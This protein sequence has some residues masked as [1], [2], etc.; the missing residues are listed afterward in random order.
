MGSVPGVLWQPV[1]A[2]T[3]HPSHW[4]PWDG[5][6]KE[7]TSAAQELS[8]DYG[9]GRGSTNQQNLLSVCGLFDDLD[10]GL[11]VKH[12]WTYS[13]HM[14][15]L[16]SGDSFIGALYTKT[17]VNALQPSLHGADKQRYKRGVCNVQEYICSGRTNPCHGSRSSTASPKNIAILYHSYSRDL[18]T[19]RF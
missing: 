1:P 2:L 6:S 19:Q 13:L 5:F 16:E 8:P 3:A 14:D 10:F 18:Q 17:L 4:Q 12:C 15:M 9:A 7:N 11:S